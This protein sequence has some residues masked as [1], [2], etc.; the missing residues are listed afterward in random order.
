M[1]GISL[2]KIWL[3]AGHGGTDPGAVGFIAEKKDTL[4]YIVEMGRVLVKLGFEVGYTRTT[5]NFVSLPDRGKMA[6]FWGADYFISIHFNAGGGTG[7]ET[8]ALA[9]GGKA[10]KLADVVQ[11]ELIASTGMASRGVKFANF[12]V[13]RDTSMPAILIE[14]GFVDHAGDVALITS[15]DW[16]HKFIQGASKA[17]CE[18]TGVTWCDPYKP[19]V[20]VPALVDIPEVVVI[21]VVVPQAVV[22]DTDVY[23]SVRVRTSKVDKLTKDLIGL[24]FA[25]KRLE[26]A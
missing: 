19:F 12:E 10:Q 6:N 1:G 2:T 7:I 21:P 8:Y 11:R 5:D 25:T 13:L 9:V 16:E 26:L 22:I 4:L 3:D 14:G 23:L 15:E 20:V 17:V 18:F 24:G